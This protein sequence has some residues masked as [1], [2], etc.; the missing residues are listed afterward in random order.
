MTA[1]LTQS[2]LASAR[3]CQRLHHL[4]YDLGVRALVEQSALSFGTLIH[5]GLEQYWL[6]SGD[7]RLPSALAAVAGESDPFLL[8]QAEVM[9][10][11][12]HNRWG[13]EP[14]D[15]LAVEKE[16]RTPLVNP[17]TGAPSRTWELA[18]K[19]DL[20]VRDRRDNRVLI[21]EHKTSSSD[22]KPGSTYWQR[23]R[24]DGQVSQY[25]VGARS[26]G[27]DV[28]GCVYDVLGKTSLRPL[29]A[30]PL[31]SRKYKKDTGE[32]YANQR[33][34]D[35]TPAEH[36]ARLLESVA[37]DP[38]RYFARGEV[39][40]L[41][42]EMTEA[43]TDIWQLGVQLR[44]AANVGSYPRNPGNCEAY[45]RMCQFFGVCTGS[46]SLDDPALFVTIGNVHPELSQQMPKEEASV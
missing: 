29:L 44:E 2:R 12:Y 3:A 16:F 26:L 34:E 27:Y 30:T 9:L 28:A 21:V 5:R 39:T 1:L 43:L 13:N 33:A 15:V 40:R 6:A 45:G 42:A 18:G 38:D 24:M 22:I 14:Y 25:Y 46:E 17:T 32:L 8:A 19:L 23:L 41:D 31:E 36:K 10:A 35:E 37:A 4:K 7:D 11:G 20:V